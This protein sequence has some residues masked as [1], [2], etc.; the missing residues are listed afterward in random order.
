MGPTDL[1]RYK[2]G[3][4]LLHPPLHDFTYAL[5]R[6]NVMPI[7]VSSNG[8]FVVIE[9]IIDASDDSAEEGAKIS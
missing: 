1:Q 6:N 8:T 4:A 5:K 2:G 9:S 7:F 3:L